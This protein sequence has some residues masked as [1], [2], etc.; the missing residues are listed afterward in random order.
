MKTIA[1]ESGKKRVNITLPEE[2]IEII[3]FLADQENIPMT[4]KAGHL[5]NDALELEEDK[6]LSEIADKRFREAKK[7]DF[8][9]EEEFWNHAFSA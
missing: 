2:T 8:I 6:V 1:T 9:S 4:T 3:A 5:I 7:E